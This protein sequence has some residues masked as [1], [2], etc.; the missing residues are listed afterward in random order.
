MRVP[1]VPQL[2]LFTFGVLLVSALTLFL[3]PS[4]SSPAFAA[5]SG[6]TL[7]GRSAQDQPPEWWFVE[8]AG[9]KERV[10][11]VQK[12]WGFTRL[13]PGEYRLTLLLRGQQ[14]FVE[15][16]PVTV[17]K[18]Q[19]TTVKVTS[20]VDASGGAQQPPP[21][22]W[23]VEKAGTKERVA[24]VQKRWGFLPLPPGTYRLTLLLRGQQEFVEWGPV[25][26][27]EDQVTPINAAAGIALTGG[28]QQPPPEAWF[29]DDATTKKRVAQVQKRWGFLP[30]PPGTYPLTLRLRGQQEFVEWGPVTVTKDQV[31]PID[32]A[33]GIALTGGPQQP[34][35]EAW[36]VDDA[37]TKKRV[38]QVQKRWG[39]LPLPPGTYQLVLVP[40]GP[41]TLDVPWGSVTVAKDHVTTVDASS[42]IDL[43]GGVQPPPPELWVVENL[44]TQKRV[45]QMPKRWGFTPLPPGRYAVKASFAN[46]PDPERVREVTVPAGRVT[47]LPVAALGIVQMLAGDAPTGAFDAPALA[48]QYGLSLF[49]LTIGDPAAAATQQTQVMLLEATG[50]R[51]LAVLPNPPARATWLT[52]PQPLVRV[53]QGQREQVFRDLPVGKLVELSSGLSTGRPGTAPDA[54]P[55]AVDIVI[56]APPDGAVV[57]HDEVTV[58]GR[59]ATTTR[60]GMTQIALII[61]A[62]GS[63]MDSS[64]GKEGSILDAEVAAGRLLLDKLVERE[65]QSPGTAFAVTLIR[66]ADD[67]EVIAPLTR[68]TDAQGVKALYDALA[69]IPQTFKG[70]NTYYDKALDQALRTFEA[71][72][73]PGNRVILFMSDGKPSALGPSLAAAARAGLGGVV[74][75]TF[76]LGEDFRGTP[77][78]TIALPPYPTDA[79]SI[80][81][82]VAQLGAAAGTVMPLPRPADVVQIIPRLPVLELAD[83]GLKEVQVINKTTGTAAAQVELTPDGA[84]QARVPVSLVPTGRHASNTL[85]ATAI[86]A[87]GVSK[88]TAEVQVRAEDPVPD[89]VIAEL[90]ARI[91]AL[92]QE[93]AQLQQNIALCNATQQALAAERDKLAETLK[94]VEADRDKLATTLREMQAKL[95][96][97]QTRLTGLE[98]TVAT[99]VAERDTLNREKTQLKTALDELRSERDK[100]AETLKAG[101]ADRD[102]LATTLRETQGELS[103][104]RTRLTGLEAE[105]EH[106]PGTLSITTVGENP[107]LVPQF[108]L[109]LDASN[110]M[111]GQ[112]K[113]QP[114]IAIAKD[115]VTRIIQRLP[116]SARVALRIYGHQHPVHHPSACQDSKLVF[117]FAKINK[118]DLLNIVSAIKPK[119][120]TPIAHSLQQVASDFRDVP[121]AKLVVL[122]TD[123]IEE[124]GGSP[125]AAVAEL[126][127]KGLQVKI[128]VVGFAL[129]DET[130]KQ[131]MERI[132]KLTGGLFFDAQDAEQLRKAL[133]QALT[134]PYEVRDASGKTVGGSTLGRGPMTLPGGSYTVVV[135]APDKPITIRNV[136]VAPNRATQVELKTE[137]GGIGI[138]IDGP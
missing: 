133:E 30:L 138:R 93:Q 61:D 128:H 16:G 105:R 103:A 98:K 115:V 79:V 31:T 62:S 123:G 68:M 67:A 49:R 84:F 81:A 4:A 72:N 44:E 32:A 20:G 40:Q 19:V 51:L 64:G 70:G 104:A 94:T 13:P 34:P 95:T 15:W 89:T 132:A 24:Q 109:L 65:A 136:Q 83:A 87:D 73:L 36:F 66:F 119:G 39:F 46:L 12:R 2:T 91:V 131:E 107:A 47:I 129:A 52:P 112:L 80:L 125:S 75:H 45:A 26:V 127:A 108:E 38:A 21:E 6:I 99:G 7:L 122:V 56:E 53:R 74:I 57:L 58:I 82:T 71:A 92:E 85:A 18:D 124:C 126:Q 3:L 134:V 106:L 100:L 130:A 76:G 42:G 28:P 113:G 8:K 35:P 9:T 17:D 60:A 118:K 88:A 11:Q 43:V 54:A 29:V 33:A 27:D 22:A 50:H 120:M 97:V 14:E 101:Q 78:A 86:A 48:E 59:A 69:R 96:A 77:P 137:S 116:D 41:Q 23:F 5:D 114:K 111:W 135:L 25:T 1:A 63:T 121:G 110:S 90:K 10:A 37:T 55:L 117:P 102:K